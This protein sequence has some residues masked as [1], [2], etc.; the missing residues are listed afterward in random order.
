MIYF[1]KNARTSGVCFKPF[2]F[3]ETSEEMASLIVKEQLNHLWVKK[4][5]EEKC[6]IPLAW[7]K[8]YEVQ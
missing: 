3:M 5:I 4:M 8:M 6:K 7:W 1:K 2:P